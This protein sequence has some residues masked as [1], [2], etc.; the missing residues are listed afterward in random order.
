MRPWLFYVNRYLYSKLTRLKFNLLKMYE[1]LRKE[2]TNL[3]VPNKCIRP[4]LANH[5]KGVLLTRLCLENLSSRLIVTYNF[6]PHKDLRIN[7]TIVEFKLCGALQCI[8]GNEHIMLEYMSIHQY[9]IGITR[10]KTNEIR[11]SCAQ[12]KGWGKY[13][14]DKKSKIYELSINKNL[15]KTCQFDRLCGHYPAHIRF[16]LFPKTFIKLVANKGKLESKLEMHF[17]ITSSKFADNFN[18]SL[19]WMPCDLAENAITPYAER[20]VDLHLTRYYHYQYHLLRVV[21]HRIH[22]LIIH[23]IGGMGALVFD[24]P[25]FECNILT[26]DQMDP[27]KSVFETTTFQASVLLIRTY[28]NIRMSTKGETKYDYITGKKLQYKSVSA[29]RKWE[30]GNITNVPTTIAI[31]WKACI[32]ENNQ[33]CIIKISNTLATG[34]NI[35]VLSLVYTGPFLP[36]HKCLFGGLAIYFKN[37]ATDK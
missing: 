28:E 15:Y 21:T 9:N 30:I 36:G 35:T 25:L 33:F 18:I 23:Q 8:T 12:G 6:S 22:T 37:N 10:R 4:T 29:Y 26:G 17:Q 19:F 5:A 1:I 16:L 2:A 24:G 31:P 34:I 14:Y 20:L 32:N 27:R 11:N 7:L 3:F 13:R